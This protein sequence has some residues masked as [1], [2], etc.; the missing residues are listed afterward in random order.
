MMS[1][2]IESNRK[3]SEQNV[4]VN[5]W[6]IT[7]LNAPNIRFVKV[8]RHGKEAVE[9]NWQ[10]FKNYS[11]N[12]SE[13]RNWMN[14]GGNYGLTSPT[15]FAC[16]IDA[17]AKEIQQ[18]LD[19]TLPETMRW[20]T[21]KEGHYQYAYFIEEGPIGCLPLKEGAYIKGKGGYALGPGNVH[22]NSVVYGSKE[23]RDVPIAT[24]KKTELI[25][26]LHDFAVSWESQ[27]H[28]VKVSIPIGSGQILM[29]LE[30]YGVDPSQYRR[31]GQWLR[32]S[33]PIHGSETGTNF[34]VNVETDTWH[35]FRHGSGG[36]VV[37]LVAVL[38]KLIECEDVKG[39]V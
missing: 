15:G 39:D 10:T 24:V 3:T 7:Q 36:G 31:T 35:C 12:S 37:S 28:R 19:S 21:G 5:P 20:S 2:F 14:N 22:P 18:I 8:R 30:E 6:L 4:N 33:H 11:F 25:N 26:A 9:R 16:F 27:T 34:A 32:G 17:D 38:E 23:F 29:V 13:I 1:Q